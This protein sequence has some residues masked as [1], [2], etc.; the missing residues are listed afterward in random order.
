MTVSLFPS[1]TKH[2]HLLSGSSWK[3]TVRMLSLYLGLIFFLT[4]ANHLSFSNLKQIQT[5]RQVATSQNQ[6]CHRLQH[7]LLIQTKITSALNCSKGLWNKFHSNQPL[8][9]LSSFIWKE[10]NPLPQESS[11]KKSW[12]KLSWEMV[13]MLHYWILNYFVCSSETQYVDSHHESS[14]SEVVK[15]ELHWQYFC[16]GAG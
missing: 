10:E 5:Y 8:E 2:I 11:E 12:F 3:S 6:S 9:K 7:S 13:N 16:G 1:K 15:M 4:M 14:L